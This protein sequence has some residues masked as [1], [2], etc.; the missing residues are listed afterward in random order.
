M[1]NRVHRRVIVQD[2]GKAIYKASSKVSLLAVLEGC[3]EGYK[4]LHTQAGILQCNM[5][6]SNLMVNEDVYNPSWCSFLIDLD[7]AIK[8]QWE[9]SSG[10]RGK[11]G[12]PAF[13]AIR[14]PLD[15][16]NHSFM[17]NLEPLFWVLFFL[18]MHSL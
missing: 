9:E 7:L 12:T 17:H 3:I 18:D 15:E 13:T 4:S 2:Y 16:A 5:S 8:E 6:P 11:A 1:A 10:A 14:V